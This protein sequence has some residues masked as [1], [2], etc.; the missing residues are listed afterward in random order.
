MINECT[1]DWQRMYVLYVCIQYIYTVSHV[2][3][4]TYIQYIFSRDNII[5]IKLGYILE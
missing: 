5:E 3:D 1:L 2:S 4:H